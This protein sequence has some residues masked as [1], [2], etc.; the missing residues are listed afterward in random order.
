MV[1]SSINRSL[2]RGRGCDVGLRR[3]PH[4][5]DTSMDS[6]IDQSARHLV[7]QA[8]Q[9]PSVDPDRGHRN[10]PEVERSDTSGCPA[11]EGRGTPNEVR[12]RVAQPVGG[13]NCWP[14]GPEGVVMEATRACDPGWENGWPFGPD[15]RPFGASRSQRTGLHIE[16]R[17]PP[18]PRPT[19]SLRHL[20]LPQPPP[21]TPATP[22]AARGR[23][24]LWVVWGVGRS[25]SSAGGGR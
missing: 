1:P 17:T 11:P 5:S 9:S 22:P 6:L 7:C 19:Q 14:V 24:S 13:R 12:E 20:T 3:W 8:T 4:D 15:E 23:G 10:E 2:P 25:R 18:V 21:K 16:G